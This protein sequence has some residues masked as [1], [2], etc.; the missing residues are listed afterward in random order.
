ML[1]QK[2][3]RDS[4]PRD[5]CFHCGGQLIWDNDYDFDDM[6]YEGSGIVH[7]LHCKDCGAEV[8]YRVEDKTDERL[9][10]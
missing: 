10:V 1:K 4:C 7:C 6:G 9:E 3:R 5:V 2:C 8:E